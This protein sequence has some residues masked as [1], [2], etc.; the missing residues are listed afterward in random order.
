M[1][2]LLKVFVSIY[3]FSTMVHNFDHLANHQKIYSICLFISLLIKQN[4]KS[5]ILICVKSFILLSIYIIFIILLLK[6]NMVC[7]N[8]KITNIYIYN[9]SLKIK[10]D[11]FY[12]II[13]FLNK[14][15][16]FFLYYCCY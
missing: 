4:R 11:F 3:F 2:L 6:I 10:Y 8:L 1:F 7:Y 14:A 16:Y 15:I 12:N 5:L 13:C 9:L